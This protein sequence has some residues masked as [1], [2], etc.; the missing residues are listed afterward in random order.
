MFHSLT[1]FSKLWAKAG[2][3][4]RRK[5]ASPRPRRARPQ[6]E[7]LE[8]RIVPAVIDVTTLADGTGAGTLRSAIAQANTNDANGDTNNTINLTVAGTYNIGQLNLGALQIFSN[9]TATQSGLSLTV[10]NTSGGNIAISGNNATRV[11]DIN[12]NDI[13]KLS[14]TVAL[15]A[16]TIND[17]T[18]ENG[19]AQPGD[20]AAGSGGGIRDQGPVDLT[21]NNDILTNNS[22]TADGGGVSMENAAS[23]HWVLTLD[24]TTV[25]NNQAGDAGGGIEEDGTGLVNI[26]NSTIADNGCVNQGGGVWLDAINGGTATLNLTNSVVSG[27][28]AGMLGGGIGNAGTSTVTL[29]GSTVAHNFTGGIGGGFANASALITTPAGTLIVQNSLFLDNSAVA[30]GGGIEEGNVLTITNSEI[31]GNVAGVNGG[32]TKVTAGGGQIER[33]GGGLFVFAGS[34]T[35][36][37][38]TVADNTA[39]AG[40]GI[41]LNTAGN[42]AITNSTIADNSAFSSGGAGLGGGIDDNL[43]AGGLTLLNDTITNNFAVL[44]GGGV[45]SINPA[46]ALSVQNTI[47]AQ[48]TATSKEGSDFFGR[49]SADLGGNLIGISGSGSGNGG[50]TSATDR[51]GTTTH[52][53]NPM[54]TGLTNNGGPLAGSTGEQMTV[55]T[56]ALLPGSPALGKGVPNSVTTDERGFNRLAPPDIGAFQFQ[57]AALTVAVTPATPTVTINGSDTFTIT[58]TNTG[59]NALPADNSMLSVALSNGLTTTGPLTFTLAAIPAGQSQTFTVT[60]TA[61]TLGTQ[62]IT[63][64]V[65]SVDANT[66][67]GSATI[68][69]VVNTPPISPPPV[70]THTPIGAL[71]LF[72][73]GFGPTGIDLFEID[74]KGEVFAQAF[75]FGGANGSPQF[76]A[77]DAVFR[78]LALM[79][80]AIVGDVLGGS[81]QPFLM[82]VLNFNDPFVFQGLLNAL[83]GK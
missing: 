58:V 12:P 70:T 83:S 44:G 40:G 18:I 1:L 10:Q 71:T 69:V 13:I 34:L 64:T 26:S 2:L 38:S 50:F 65:S 59:G 60:T 8:D 11:F 14:P 41:D 82:E 42:V 4:N 5:P 24:N 76:V 47:V 63:A 9:A 45:F 78:N 72:G 23:T 74:G 28:T 51:T 43:F 19:L 39:V 81:G 6:L 46:V 55:E 68:H 29:A 25:S 33:V 15:D 77:A 80:G 79:N 52:P 56:E 20:G 35:L 53:L 61:T 17:V 16:V 30:G 73:F 32:M 75:G 37:D 54:V 27:N 22:A 3:G 21:L 49:P 31:K 48:N 62:S 36:T 57:N 67:S 7:Y 66:V